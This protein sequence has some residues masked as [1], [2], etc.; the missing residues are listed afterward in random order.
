MADHVLTTLA[1]GGAYFEAPRW[2]DGRWWVSDLYRKGIYTYTTAGEEEQ[3]VALEHQPSGL[4]FMPDGSL[5]YVSQE[6]QRIY[7]R[8]DDG[9]VTL[10]ADLSE[11]CVGDLNDLVVDERGY[12]YAGYFG[13]NP[14]AAEKPAKAGVI[15]VDPRGGHRLAAD[16]LLFPNGSVITAD[17]RTLIVGEGMAGAYTAFPI[18]D[19][20]SLGP[21]R[22]WAA[23]SK[24][25]DMASF[26]ALLT[27][28]DV[29][30]DGC[31]LDAEGMLWSADVQNARV[32]RVREGGDIVD[33]IKAPE[34]HNIFACMLGGHDGRTLLLCVAPGLVDNDRLGGLAAT[35]QT[36]QVAVPGAGRP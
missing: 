17:G 9:T 22:T 25:P 36:V 3:I 23:L 35:L 33:E 6:D 8:A 5:L 4:G 12:A 30:V 21:R 28:L 11:H 32:I 2:H 10:H 26:Q 13:F 34:G 31:C 15:G 16:D 27:S 24:A 18:E 29:L 20:G 19:D 14:F 7:R 1:T